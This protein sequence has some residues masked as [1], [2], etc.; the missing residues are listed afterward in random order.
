LREVSGGGQDIDIVLHELSFVL[1]AMI[2]VVVKMVVA[3][4]LYFILVLLC[5]DIGLEGSERELL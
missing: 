1:V 2:V 5:N 4:P 3:V